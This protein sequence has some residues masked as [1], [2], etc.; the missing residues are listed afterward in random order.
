MRSGATLSEA[1]EYLMTH[2]IEIH[3][4]NEDPG[5]REWTASPKPF[6]NLYIDDAAL[7]CPLKF[8]PKV[9]ARPFVDWD[10]VEKLLEERGIL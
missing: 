9:S 1:V 4:V 10:K 2:G 3:G 5:Q 7:G 8:D 6:G